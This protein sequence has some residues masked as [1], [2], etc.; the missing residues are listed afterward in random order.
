MA[1]QRTRAGRRTRQCGALLVA[2]VVLLVGCDT[3]EGLRG[4]DDETPAAPVVGS[5][6]DEAATAAAIDVD[7]PLVRPASDA[8]VQ[9]LC[10]VDPFA[11][12]GTNDPLA[13]LADAYRAVS[14]TSPEEADELARIV[15]AIEDAHDG[16]DLEAFTDAAS[17]VRA[18]CGAVVL[19]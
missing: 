12:A 15:S 9:Q 10:G 8:Y 19:R 13:A 5:P 1:G 16:E 2:L 6:G 14:T 3:I 18:R 17:V 4:G 11:V 7:Q